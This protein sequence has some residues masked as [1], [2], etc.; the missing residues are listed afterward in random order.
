MQEVVVG[1]LEHVDA[2]VALV[3]AIEQMGLRDDTL[4]FT[5]LVTM[6]QAP[7]GLT[8]TLNVMR[9]MLGL[10]DDVAS[11]LKHIDA[12]GGPQFENH[13]PVSWCWAGSSPFHWMKQIASH[14]GGTRN[15]MVM[16]WPN[17]IIDRGGLRSQFHHVIDIA[18]TIL[19]VA[20]IPEPRSVNGVPQ[21]PI[22]GV[23][24][25]Y[26]FADKKR[27]WTTTDAVL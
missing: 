25:A 26:T 10:P 4:I 9:T 15:G 20:G 8:G 12:M 16:S 22:E 5:S 21:K 27:T 6:D 13:Y 23:S 18:P 19:E 24:M 7:K 3:D 1:F 11:M 2:Q 14:F 17:Q